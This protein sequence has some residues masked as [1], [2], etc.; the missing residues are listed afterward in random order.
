MLLDAQ[1]ILLDE[2]STSALLHVSPRT[3]ERWRAQGRGP[4]WIKFARNCVRYERRAIAD[5]IQ[6]KRIVFQARD[7]MRAA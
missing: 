5:F 7:A 1:D 2:R 6:A 4:E 3:L